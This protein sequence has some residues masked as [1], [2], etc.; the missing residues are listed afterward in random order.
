MPQHHLEAV[1]IG[2]IVAAGDHDA[3]VDVELGLGIIEH[4]RR[5]EADPDDVDAARGRGPRPA[6]PRGPAS[7]RAR[8]GRPR[9]CV[10]PPRRTRVPKV[11]PT[12]WASASPSVSPKIPLMS[13]SRR[14]VGWQT[15][16]HSG[17]PIGGMRSQDARGG[18]RFISAISVS[19]AALTRLA[20]SA[21]PPASGWTLAISR[22]W[23]A[24][25]SS[26]VAPSADAEQ[27]PRVLDRHSGFGDGPRGARPPRA[28]RRAISAGA[29][30]QPAVGEQAEAEQ[31][32]RGGNA[33]LIGEAL[34]P[35]GHQGPEQAAGGEQD[36]RAPSLAGGRGRAARP[37]PPAA[38]P[39]PA[40][41]SRSSW[42]AAI[43][44]M[45]TSPRCGRSS[46]V[47]PLGNSSR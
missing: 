12:A 37:R 17:T 10:P 46:R 14:E 34:E 31:E 18:L 23:A 16:A 30:E 19:R 27:A 9:P 33:V 38:R 22:R 5:P 29:G 45:P 2:R 36:Q 41:I 21:E 4:R 32:E 44:L 28:G 47:R 15:M 24:R 7:F 6:P 20:S 26:G 11:R 25:I 13:Y 43:W 39:K 8:R 40:I 3:A 42:R 35:A 1:I